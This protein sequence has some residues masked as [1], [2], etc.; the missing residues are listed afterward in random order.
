MTADG[1]PTAAPT[2]DAGPWAGI[3]HRIQNRVSSHGMSLR[4][5]PRFED[6]RL[7]LGSLRWTRPYFEAW[8][9]ARQSSGPGWRW[10]PV[11]ETPALRCGLIRL[12]PHGRIPPH[13]HTDMRGVLMVTE[14]CVRVFRYVV[15][16]SVP[17]PGEVVQLRS[18]PGRLL[19]EG[20]GSRVDG[21]AGDVH[22]LENPGSGAAVM[23]DLIWHGGGRP[24]RHYFVCHRPA[25]RSA[26]QTA[27]LTPATVVSESRVRGMHESGGD[28]IEPCT[29]CWGGCT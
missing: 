21:F 24:E 22:G 29:T 25:P 23:L 5:P 14:G 3:R 19:Q 26:A 9:A 4:R 15:H 1:N 6:L 28:A 18:Y 16:G 8:K 13:D 17:A 12:E 20:D 11:L 2:P 27:A 7:I 10:I